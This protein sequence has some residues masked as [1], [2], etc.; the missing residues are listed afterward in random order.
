MDL[1]D[2]K[3]VFQICS[4]LLILVNIYKIENRNSI[5]LSVIMFMI[6]S[7][8]TVQGVRLRKAYNNKIIRYIRKICEYSIWIIAFILFVDEAQNF[9]I[10]INNQIFKNIIYIIVSFTFL[11]CILLTFFT[12]SNEEVEEL[13]KKQVEK[14]AINFDDAIQ[15]VVKYVN[16]NGGWSKFIKTTIGQQ[17]ANSVKM[18][19][20]DKTPTDFKKLHKRKKYK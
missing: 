4:F 3:R 17:F 20:R 11:Y 5:E 10:S 18:R 19:S 9:T 15:E 14:A 12:M 6:S 8:M 7:F 2:Y 13:I 1:K 16:E